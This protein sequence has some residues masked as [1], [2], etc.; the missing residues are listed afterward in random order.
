MNYS[1][2]FLSATLIFASLLPVSFA[3]SKLG[4]TQIGVTV[5]LTFNNQTKYAIKE[6]FCEPNRNPFS[7]IRTTTMK[8]FDLQSSGYMEKKMV[9]YFPKDS[10]RSELTFQCLGNVQSGWRGFT[11]IRTD[12]VSV[13]VNKDPRQTVSRTVN[14]LAENEGTFRFEVK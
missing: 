5:V 7:T 9:L 3:A 12:K 1:K 14:I 11:P 4:N 8:P 10:G 6:L 2:L 13:R